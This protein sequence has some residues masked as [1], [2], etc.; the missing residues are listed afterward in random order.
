MKFIRPALI[1]ALMC[2]SAAGASFANNVRVVFDPPI[3]IGLIGGTGGLGDLLDPSAVYIV[4]T[5]S[6][7][8][9]GP[10]AVFN[11][12][13]NDTTDACIALLNQ[14]NT[15]LSSFTVSFV[16]TQ[17]IVTNDLPTSVT[18]GTTLADTQLLSNI[19]DPNGTFNVGDTV[20]VQFFAADPSQDV[21]SGASIFVDIQGI[22]FNDL[23]SV[24]VT[25]PEPGS[26]AL[27]AAGM[28]LVGLCMAFVKR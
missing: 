6:C 25:A 23:G 2:F 20:S 15:S 7:N 22:S 19:C 14:T 18:C 10:E 26:F 9:A 8:T 27:L 5:E 4:P 17:A 21:P 11:P 28:G 1:V 12:P 16:L 13:A 24:N 3:A